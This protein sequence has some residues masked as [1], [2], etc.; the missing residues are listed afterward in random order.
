MVIGLSPSLPHHPMKPTFSRLLAASITSVITL[1]SSAFAG[2]IWKDSTTGNLNLT[3]SWWTT[4]TGTTDPTAIS[5]TDTLRF[6]GSGQGAS[7]TS[8]GLGGDLAVGALRLDNQT[9]T[10]NYNVAIAAGNTLTLNGNND[11]SGGIAQGIVLNSGSPATGVLTVNSNIIVG[12]SQRWVSSR[13]LNVGGNV[14]LGA[15]T[16]GF[17]SAAGTTTVSGNISGTGGIAK[18]DGGSGALII[19]NT[20]NSYQGGTTVAT[21][22]LQALASIAAGAKTTLGSGAVTVNS[23]TS[24][25][26]KTGGTANAQSY[27]NAINL[28]SGT[29]ISEDGNLTIGGAVALTGATNTVNV[30]YS[31]KSVSFTSPITGAGGLNKTNVGTMN[32]VNGSY[33]GATTVS[34]GTL[35][36]TGTNS[37]TSSVTVNGGASLVV[38]TGGIL[39]TAG[40]LTTAVATGANITVETGATLNAGSAAIAWNPGTFKV[41]GALA[42]TNALVVSTNNTATI[43]G[44]GTITAGSFATGNSATTVNFTNSG[45]MTLGGNL[46]VTA[47][48]SAAFNQSAG[49]IKAAGI[50]LNA[51]ASTFAITGGRMNLGVGG[52]A[53]TGATKT[54]NLG[55]GTLGA[56]ANWS[57][58]AAMAL[59][60]TTTGTTINTADSVDSTARSI[61][62]SG[63]LSGTNGKLNKDGD[64]TLVLSSLTNSYTGPTNVNKGTL[65]ISG[66]I[67]TS[68]LTT[69]AAGAT[70]TGS[71]TTGALT[72]LGDINPGNSPGI[73]TTTGNFNLSGTYNAELDGTTVG[74]GYDQIDV[75]GTVTLRG[76]LNLIT[77]FTATNDDLFFLIKND[78]T[79]AI[80]GTFAG[81][82]DGASFFA[83]TQKYQISYFGNAEAATPTFT[84]GNDVALMAIPEPS[85]ALLGGLGLLA[86]LR[87]RRY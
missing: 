60:S 64:G 63:A 37:G 5:A 51:P 87:R 54:I 70:I 59:T 38:K 56:T 58:S 43:S 42:I 3:T 48:T 6:G 76:V 27:A 74:T 47:S 53:G 16:L 61:T 10:P 8:L 62:L 41:D 22:E 13:T 77:S 40:A 75:T 29:L 46:T 19:S 23:G 69:V 67:S 71:G 50:L 4:E 30:I 52:I 39:T 57:S 18:T 49:T 1:S 80:I 21:G 66:N 32:M 31:D 11:Y 45:S 79:D 82:A 44:V 15:N 83:G 20:G 73:L 12:A 17:W 14:A 35:A 85:A 81:L 7:M 78:G 72:V 24:V 2:S 86:L 28:N 26:F 34:G 68:L 84:G 33:A 55:A 36:I 65:V 25:R 9:G